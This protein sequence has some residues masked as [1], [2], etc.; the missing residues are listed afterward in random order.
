MNGL[1]FVAVIDTFGGVCDGCGE[2]VQRYL[3]Q[4]TTALVSL[5]ISTFQD[6]PHTH[7]EK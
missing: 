1:T 7:T 2:T 4:K 3:A 5:T 6:M